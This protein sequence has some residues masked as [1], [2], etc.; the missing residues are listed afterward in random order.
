M[1]HSVLMW[2]WLCG[3][4]CVDVVVAVV[5]QAGGDLPDDPTTTG[6]GGQ[7]QDLRLFAGRQQCRHAGKYVTIILSCRSVR[8]H[9]FMSERHHR[10][11]L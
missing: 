2:C 9:H 8:H 10:I 3:I 11:I 1:E 5:Y 7:P 4:Q 6:G